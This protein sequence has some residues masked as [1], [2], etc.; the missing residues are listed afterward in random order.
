MNILFKNYENLYK[1]LIEKIKFLNLQKYPQKINEY[2]EE[3]KKKIQEYISSI[4]SGIKDSVI[5][6]K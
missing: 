2:K 6:C 3:I 5:N 1:K 4:G